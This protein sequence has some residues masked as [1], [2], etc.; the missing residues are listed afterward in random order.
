MLALAVLGPA[1]GEDAHPQVF[2]RDLHPLR[3]DKGGSVMGYGY[4][5]LWIA[6]AGRLTR[7]DKVTG[8]MREILLRSSGEACRTIAAGEG[9]VWVPDC[10]SGTVDKVEPTGRKV[11]EI[12]AEMFSRDGSIAV[13]AGAV[14]VITAG[15]GERTLTRFKA[16]DGEQEAEIALPFSGTCV[17]VA[18]GS[19]WVTAA[20]KGEL[21]RLDPAS[22]TLRSRLKLGG[23]PKAL[24]SAD[25]SIF[26]FNEALGSI[27]RVDPA[28]NQL[29]RTIK[30]GSPGYGDIDVGGGSIWVST[31]EIPL[32]E[33]D[34]R[35]NALSRVFRS[36]GLPSH[37]FYMRYGEGAVWFVDW[38]TYRVELPR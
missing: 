19:V 2:L 13:G 22:N 1:S 32:G 12:P 21:F 17:L 37:Q 27:Q 7:I 38:Q 10:G 31:A 28:S 11:A 23:T 29:V 4:G 16:A 5:A 26:V 15:D 18:E 35:T 14:W 6:S 9:A 3:I 33:V 20:G 25:G 30:I 34:P 8:E 24:A 36:D